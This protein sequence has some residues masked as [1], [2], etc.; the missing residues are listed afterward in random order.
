MGIDGCEVY[1]IMFWD[2]VGGFVEK[3]NFKKKLD[4]RAPR[5]ACTRLGAR[6]PCTIVMVIDC[7]EVYIMMFWDHVYGFMEK[8][9]QK[10]W[11]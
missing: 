4:N 1:I 2:H 7:W 10:L 6:A 5:G 8:N 3:Q 9:I 11:T